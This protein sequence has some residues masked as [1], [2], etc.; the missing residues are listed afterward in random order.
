MAIQISGQSAKTGAP[1][2]AL[3][4]DQQNA[5]LV[6]E[7]NP[8]YYQN[9][10][11]GNS[12]ILSTTAANAT[13]AFPFAAAGAPL[14]A[15][16][17]PVGSG[18]NLILSNV[19]IAYETTGTG[20]VSLDFGLSLAG[21]AILGSGTVTAP[22]NLL[23]YQQSGSVAKGFINTALT[24]NTLSTSVVTIPILSV[25]LTTAT[26][27]VVP[28]PALF[29]MGG[30]VVVAPGNLV[31]LGASATTTAAKFDVSLLWAELPI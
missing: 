1:G 2:Q 7:I 15:L 11:A 25:G 19:G 12:Y 29:D 13:G 14:L 28:V 10:Y 23:S 31:T 17:N 21:V 22:T 3:P 16:F 24:S 20:A 18:K 30:L 27:I 6:T 4:Q 9:V 8:R 26:S 5:L